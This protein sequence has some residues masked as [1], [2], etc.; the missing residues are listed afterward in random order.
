[1]LIQKDILDFKAT[2]G[3]RGSALIVSLVMLLLMTL[4][5]VASMQGT[6]LQERMAGN[7][8]D[9]E[10]A[11]EATETALRV[12]EEWAVANVP[13]AMNEELL[14]SPETWDGSEPSG[15]VADLDDQLSADP[16]FHV[17]WQGE[18][19]PPGADFRTPCRDILA[20]T[21]RGQGGS[22]T[23]TVVIQSRVMP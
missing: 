19:C 17:V 12:G 16:A 14:V 7:L 5:G 8:R 2:R 3:Q 10:M 1:M 23:T 22:D 4:V 9:R 21:A 6:I 13:A 11:F 18:V 15:T 20:V